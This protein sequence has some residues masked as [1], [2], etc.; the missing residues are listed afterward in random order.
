MTQSSIT[1]SS[2]GSALFPE[3]D[4]LYDLITAEVTGLTD[5]QLDFESDKW[6]WSEWS[7]RRQL[8]HMASLLFRWMLVRWGDALFPDGEHGVADVEGVAASSYDRRLDERRYWELQAILGQLR[9]GIELTRKVMAERDVG[10]LRGNSIPHQRS[11][12][13]ILMRKAHPTGIVPASDAE[14]GTI[15]LEATFRHMYFEEITHLY[16]IQR[17]KR[18]QGLQA[19][20][21]VPRVGY[22][23]LDGWDRSEP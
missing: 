7:I 9:G 3:Y 13:W 20:V 19:A 23:M 21:D 22:W 4:S 16:N 5:A 12:Q 10:F 8:S 18:A 17:L 1:E 2:P 14:Q 11:P 6:E 15:T